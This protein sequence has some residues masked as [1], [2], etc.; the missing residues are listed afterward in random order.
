MNENENSTKKPKNILPVVLMVG[1]AILV[2][3]LIFLI[4]KYKQL[5]KRFDQTLQSATVTAT[6][7]TSK[8]AVVLN[9]PT[10]TVKPSKTVEKTT[11]PTVSVSDTDLI[12][13]AI[14]DKLSKNV[15]EISVTINKK[16]ANNAFGGVTIEGDMGGGYFVAVKQGDGWIIIADGNGTIECSVLDQYSVPGSIVGE[17][18]DSATGESR[19]R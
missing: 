11:E 15:S 17:C 10:A 7:A 1:L 2:A 9:T 12:T 4:F 19:S 13:R 14:A 6:A 18:Y 8:T 3:V 5:E 16:D